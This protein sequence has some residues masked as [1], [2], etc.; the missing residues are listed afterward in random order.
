MRR[1]ARYPS[2]RAAQS[3]RGEDLRRDEELRRHEQAQLYAESCRGSAPL[4]DPRQGQ[5]N[6][7]WYRDHEK[8]GVARGLPDH[9]RREAVGKASERSRRPPD[10]P[11]AQDHEGRRRRDGHGNDHHEVPRDDRTPQPGGRHGQKAEQRSRRVFSEVE[12]G[13]NEE[14]I[15]EERVQ[16]VG[17][18]MGRPRHHPDPEREI[19]GDAE[20]TAGN[21]SQG[22]PVR[23]QSENEVSDDHA[24]RR[25]HFV[26][27]RPLT[28]T[29]V[30]EFESELG[31][32][33]FGRARPVSVI[34]PAYEE[35][36]TTF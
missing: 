31:R 15:A 35:A 18:R 20:E 27:S 28:D 32:G 34:T 22:W 11:F 3:G 25:Q 9:V 13:R 16:P 36:R 2:A 1:N 24:N 4:H 7:R 12:T 6:Q 17:D 14:G 29:P 30:R 26:P 8:L 33:H 19:A 23:D 5:R 21:V 10:P